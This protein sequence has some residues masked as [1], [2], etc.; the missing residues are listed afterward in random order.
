MD[1]LVNYEMRR[2]GQTEMFVSPIGLGCW[3][4]AGMTSLDVN[5]SDSRKTIYT[6]IESGINFLDTAH[7][8]GL[9]GVS[10]RLVGE[11]IQTR[12]DQL[13]IASKGGIHWD[14]SGTR[15]YDASPKRIFR[16]CD[17]SL[18]RMNLDVI[19]LYYLH[20]ADPNVPV[21]E[22]A[23]AFSKLLES[24][25]I[26]AAAV[27]NLNIEQMDSF[28]SVCPITAA[29]P[30]Y[31]ML[32]RE[33]EDELLPW[34]LRQ[35]I[36]VIT[37]WPLMK[38]LL[39]GKIRRGHEF[40]ATDKRLSYDVFQGEAFER[41]QKLLDL[42][43]QIA[44]QSGKTVAQIV[45]NWTYHQSGILSVLCGAKRD[46]QIRETAGALGWQLSQVQLDEIDQH[47][48]AAK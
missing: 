2:L 38:G 46:W 6:A 31:N 35:G 21:D 1:E 23:G 10:E 29:Q 32:Q 45:V 30:P 15:H 7:C 47:L 19:D 20:A 42:L 13:I 36:S 24:G 26:R 48:T 22:S 8:Y 25:K 33:I 12:R 39:A 41:A 44:D 5:E 43:D 37:Y 11:V 9:D 28:Q 17:E 14:A 27:S 4:I 40:D 16:E 34:S 3:P 18:R